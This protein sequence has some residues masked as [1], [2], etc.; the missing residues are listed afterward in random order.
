M[1]EV[2]DVSTERRCE[3]VDGAKIIVRSSLTFTIS[4]PKVDPTAMQETGSVPKG[5]THFATIL[6]LGFALTL[7]Y[8]YLSIFCNQDHFLTVVRILQPV[9]RGLVAEIH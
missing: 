8:E 6:L 9:T 5:V 2:L 1:T 4:C 7:T 3:R